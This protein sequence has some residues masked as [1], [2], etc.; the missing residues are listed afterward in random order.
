MPIIDSRD[1]NLQVSR[2]VKRHHEKIRRAMKRKLPEI[3]SEEEIITS[4]NRGKKI[5]I[6]IKSMDI[7][8]LRRGK[9][10]KD[11]AGSGKSG[12]GQGSGEE[13]DGIAQ[14]PGEGGDGSGSGSG[15]GLSEDVVE[16]EFTLEEI[17]EMMF[18]DLGLPNLL[19]KDLATIEIKFG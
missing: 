19:K 2:D 12:I 14:K 5:R 13:G 18:K 3:M 9:R 6:P 7:P 11:I 4:D 10:N 16:S 15:S 8:D 17:I 1:E